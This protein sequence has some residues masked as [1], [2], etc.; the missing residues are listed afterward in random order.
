V[1]LALTLGLP[2]LAWGQSQATEEQVKFAANVEMVK[3]HLL[4]RRELY[5]MGQ[6]ASPAI[7]AAHPVQEL[8]SLLRGPLNR[9]SIDLASRIGALLE[10]PGREI[11]ARVPAKQYRA[12][13]DAVFATMD[14]AVSRV[15][16]AS[17]RESLA[18]RA[19]V[20]LELLQ[21]VEEEYAEG[22]TGGR[23]AESVEYQDAYGFFRRAQAL[24]RPVAARVRT[25]VPEAAKKIERALATL[26]KG[27]TRVV[28]PATPL[29]A[30]KVQKEVREIVAELGKVAGVP[31]AIRGGAVEEIRSTRTAIQQAFEAYKGSQVAKAEELVTGAYLDHFEK[32][33]GPLE[34]KDKNLEKRLE[35]LIRNDLRGKIKAKAPV[36]EVEQ[37]VR[38]IL[39]SLD[40]A[41]KLL[42][43]Y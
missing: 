13:V 9:A 36:A 31:V 35:Q 5:A 25:N 1:A 43:A 19:R 30:E 34:Q 18:F 21:H 27:F 32:A 6:E 29:S 17:I 37:L 41:E 24:Y 14:D 39:A 26:A 7:H 8:W 15:V 20:L 4:S 12:T 16:P 3:G 33:E 40:Q 10:K 11:D 22:V 42:E 38:T 23:V 2:L 28:P